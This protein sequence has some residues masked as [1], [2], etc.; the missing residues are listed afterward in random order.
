MKDYTRVTTYMVKR[1][2]QKQL[3]YSILPKRLA[4]IPLGASS[5]S[6]VVVLLS[7]RVESK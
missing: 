5:S 2:Y 3:A 4:M 1:Y 7:F 6:S